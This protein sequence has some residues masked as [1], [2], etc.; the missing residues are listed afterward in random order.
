MTEFRLL[1]AFQVLALPDG[2]LGASH[3][4][5][6]AV[7]DEITGFRFASDVRPPSEAL[8][9]DSYIKWARANCLPTEYM[10]TD[11]AKH[12]GRI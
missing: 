11:D 4:D 8:S 7:I 2:L 5:A 10:T 12:L 6:R 9:L 1:C 3:K